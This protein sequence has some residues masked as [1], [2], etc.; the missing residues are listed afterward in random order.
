MTNPD[1]TSESYK[2][3]DCSRY[4]EEEFI[5]FMGFCF[6]DLKD[7]TEGQ[8][9]CMRQAFFAGA[10]M[11]IRSPNIHATALEINKFFKD[12]E[13]YNKDAKAKKALEN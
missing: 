13:H 11:S 6:T 4:L 8:M 12:L 5:I 9:R 10:S 1:K 2:D 7:V 3:P